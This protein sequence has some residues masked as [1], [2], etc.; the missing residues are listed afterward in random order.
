MWTWTFALID[1]S[2]AARGEQAHQRGHRFALHRT[3]DVP[4]V[5]AALDET[6]VSQHVEVVRERRAWHFHRFLDLTHRHFAF[7]SGEEDEDLQPRQMGESVE[8]F[9]MALVGLQLGEWERH[10]RI[11]TSISIKLPN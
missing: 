4:L 2:S 7:G 11:H 6:R 1:A 8:G 10:H 9:D 5:P 3:V